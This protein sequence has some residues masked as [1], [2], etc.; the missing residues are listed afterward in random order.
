MATR[1]GG[2]SYSHGRRDAMSIMGSRKVQDAVKAAAE[3]GAKAF[4]QKAAQGK[5]SGAFA[6]NV[7]VEPARGWDGRPGYRI[8][9]FPDRR[10][11]RTNSPVAIEFGTSDTRG[12][13][14]GQAAI[15]E[16]NRSQRGRRR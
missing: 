3:R 2:G 5:R 11:T 16:I 4:R 7:R 9:A 14:A 8:V 1:R 6:R 12:A 13:N 15:N 10:G